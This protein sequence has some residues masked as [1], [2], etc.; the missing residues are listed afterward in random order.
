MVY[1]VGD[2][3]LEGD[4]IAEDGEDIEEGDTLPR[5]MYENGGLGSIVYCGAPS[6][7][8]QDVRLEGF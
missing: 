3:K 8:S 1:E 2:E 5:A 7:G 6:W 4:R